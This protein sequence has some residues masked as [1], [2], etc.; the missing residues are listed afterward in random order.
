M[1]AVGVATAASSSDNGELITRRWRML[2][3]RGLALGD[4][5]FDCFRQ[6]KKKVICLVIICLSIKI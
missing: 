1:S 6:K 2:K 3:L 5:A 4:G